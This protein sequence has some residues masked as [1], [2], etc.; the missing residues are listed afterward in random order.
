VALGR[1]D[2]RTDSSK[3]FAVIGAVRRVLSPR[4]VS[5]TAALDKAGSGRGDV[6]VRSMVE[7]ADV[8]ACGRLSGCEHI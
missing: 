3:P 4:W 5:G 7:M 2:V 1:R 8:A 6:D